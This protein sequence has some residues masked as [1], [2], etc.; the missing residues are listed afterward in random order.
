MQRYYEVIRVMHDEW[1]EDFKAFIK[2]LE[3]KEMCVI[4]FGS[5]AKGEDNL[6]SNF[7]IVIIARDKED[8]ALE[9]VFPADLF[10]YTI[11]DCLKEIENKN[12]VLL[13]AFTQGKVI[14]DDIGVFNFLKNE[15]KYVIERSGLKRC[16]EGWL[17]KEVG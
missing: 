10:C 8:L 2:G 11:E 17:V 16:E 13:D 6:L 1:K 3:R 12:T 14:F 15:V 4:L 9:I 5:K 7:D